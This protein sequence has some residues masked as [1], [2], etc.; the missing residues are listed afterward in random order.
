MWEKIFPNCHLYQLHLIEKLY[1]VSNWTV[2]HEKRCSKD[3]SDS[4]WGRAVVLCAGRGGGL[5]ACLEVAP[6]LSNHSSSGSTKREVSKGWRRQALSTD[7]FP[8]VRRFRTT[9]I[10]FS[11]LCV[12]IKTK[13]LQKVQYNYGPSEPF[14]RSWCTF[15]SSISGN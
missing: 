12:Q 11:F 2:T 13:V 14:G 4:H 10:A 3:F 9:V 1:F 5:C 15:G 6:R 8:V 7:C